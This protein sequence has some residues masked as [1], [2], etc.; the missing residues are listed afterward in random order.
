MIAALPVAAALALAAG[1]THGRLTASL[2]A[3]TGWASEAFLGA[4]GGG[5]ALGQLSPSIRLDVSVTPRVKLAAD[6]DASLGRYLDSRFTTTSGAANGEIRLLLD[7]LEVSLVAGGE[8]LVDSEPAP[9]DPGLVGSPLVTASTAAVA[10]ARAR[11]RGGGI[12]A[13]LAATGTLR[14]SRPGDGGPTVE[15]QEGIAAFSVDASPHPRLDLSV[16]IGGRGAA[17][18]RPDFSL[19]SVLGSAALHAR[20]AG[21]LSADVAGRW[22]RARRGGGAR[23]TGWEAQAGLA[24]PLGDAVALALAWSWL[25]SDSSAP[26]VS[27]ASRQLILLAV[28]GRLRTGLW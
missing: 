11:L 22:E 25:F 6:A 26:D 19:R 21:D 24:Y 9:L 4:T 17:A 2:L 10:T 18:D 13:G 28:R 23:E 15:Q 20:L 5:D 1:E 12:V 27:A 7:E 16:A 3:G 8:R 14:A